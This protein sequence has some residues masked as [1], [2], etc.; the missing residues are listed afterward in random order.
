MSLSVLSNG[1]ILRVITMSAHAS[2]NHPAYTNH[3]TPA[4][5]N[6]KQSSPRLQQG[7]C[8]AKQWNVS[9]T[10]AYIFCFACFIVS[11]HAFWTSSHRNCDN[12]SPYGQAYRAGLYSGST[13]VFA[14]TLAHGTWS[15]SREIGTKAFL[16]TEAKQRRMV[17]MPI[18]VGL[19]AVLQVG[20]A[21]AH[22]LAAWRTAGMVRES[23]LVP[24]VAAVAG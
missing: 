12:E 1:V 15:D 3:G 20:A 4:K 9:Q 16:T 14:H 17:R 7:S 13:C 8:L 22:G 23:R 24:L 11:A 6:Q 2:Q 18:V 10:L 21:G 5:S 19:A